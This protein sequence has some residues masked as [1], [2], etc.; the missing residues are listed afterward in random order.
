VRL[1]L[2]RTGK[3][4]DAVL[5]GGRSQARLAVEL[6]L[7]R[8]RPPVHRPRVVVEHVDSRPVDVLFGFLL[9]ADGAVIGGSGQ[10]HAIELVVANRLDGGIKNRLRID[11]ARRK[12][13]LRGHRPARQRQE[14]GEHQRQSELSRHTALQSEA[15]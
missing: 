7:H 6:L 10:S 5:P 15:R 9:L 13:L 8:L 14:T 1:R 12:L 11:E 4:P 2:D 3:P